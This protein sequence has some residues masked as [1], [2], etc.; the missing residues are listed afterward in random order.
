MVSSG[1]S[2]IVLFPRFPN[3]IEIFDGIPVHCKLRVKGNIVPAIFQI[4]MKQQSDI[5]IFI[6]KNHK[7]PDEKNN[8]VVFK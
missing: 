5:C 6:S 2:C 8:Q 1:D 4:R 7:V 3:D